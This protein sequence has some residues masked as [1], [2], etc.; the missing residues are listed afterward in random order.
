MGKNDAVGD[1][2]ADINKQY[3]T[4]DH[5]KAVQDS[6]D[7]NQVIQ[8]KKQLIEELKRLAELKKAK[9]DALAELEKD[10]NK[11]HITD[12]H[13]KAIQDS[14]NINQVN[15]AKIEAIQDAA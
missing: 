9:N 7:I 12:A 8:V 11:Q 14:T 2:E 4:N 1:L 10:V 13:R 15:E 5:K 6:T 3:F